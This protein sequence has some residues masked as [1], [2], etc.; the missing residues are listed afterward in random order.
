MGPHCAA[1]LTLASHA[2]SR[3]AGH[4]LARYSRGYSPG[5]PVPV[6]KPWSIGTLSSSQLTVV[7]APCRHEWSIA[8]VVADSLRCA[9]CCLA[10][11]Q[12]DPRAAASGHRCVSALAGFRNFH[13]NVATSYLVRCSPARAL[14]PQP[15]R[16]PLGL[17]RLPRAASGSGHVAPGCRHSHGRRRSRRARQVSTAKG[18]GATTF[19]DML[20]DAA[21]GTAAA[22]LPSVGT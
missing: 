22:T 11:P 13:L 21:A 14:A 15:T 5:P 18:T 20:K 19:R 4:S 2:R 6:T 12:Q 8:R 1:R 7:A 3:Q 16:S 9:Q 10:A 17:V